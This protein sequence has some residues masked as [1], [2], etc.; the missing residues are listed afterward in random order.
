MHRA[1]GSWPAPISAGMV[2]AQGVRLAQPS[3]DGDDVYWLEGRPAEAGRT[4]LVRRTP[5][6]RTRD[7]IPAGFNVRTRVHEYG[8]GAYVVG[9]G[10]AYFA[11]FA[12]QRWYRVAVDE[13]DPR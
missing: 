12:D 1:A 11:N 5:D 4:V 7:A 3:I 8:G 6:G 2:A 10:V 9:G 13:D